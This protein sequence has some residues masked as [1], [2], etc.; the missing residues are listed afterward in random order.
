VVAQEEVAT[1]LVEIWDPDE[2]LLETEAGVE[3]EEEE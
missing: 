3:E 1:G 2:E